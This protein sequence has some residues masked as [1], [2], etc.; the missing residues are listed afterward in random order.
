MS[1]YLIA[2]NVL[3]AIVRGS[4]ADVDTLRVHSSLPLVGGKPVEVAVEGGECRVSVQLDVRF[5]EFIPGLAAA[6]RR[7]IAQALRFMTGLRVTTVDII[8]SGVFPAAR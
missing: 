4:L 1:Q 8:I 5:G 6:A 7:R 3:E 2:T